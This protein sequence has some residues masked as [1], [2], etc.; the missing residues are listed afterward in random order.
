[1]GLVY[2]PIRPGVVPEGSLWG[3]S[4]MA[5]PCVV[6]GYYIKN[7]TFQRTGQWGWL[8]DSRNP[9]LWSRLWT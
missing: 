6:S 8:L 4:P 2:L 7:K 1:M 3:G 5:V 9:H